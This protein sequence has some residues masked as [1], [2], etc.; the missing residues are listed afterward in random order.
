[1]TLPTRGSGVTDARIVFKAVAGTV[2]VQERGEHRF[3]SVPLSNALRTLAE[4][5]VLIARDLQAAEGQVNVVVEEYGDHPFTAGPYLDTLL[6]ETLGAYGVVF[7]V[8]RLKLLG[9]PF[10]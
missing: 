4:S 7:T 5:L 9:L 3:Y 6:E 10:V 2:Q 1:M 8:S